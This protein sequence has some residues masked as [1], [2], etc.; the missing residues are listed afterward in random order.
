M[1]QDKIL[2]LREL[3]RSRAYLIDVAADLKRKL[4]A[5]LDR[6]FPEYESLFESLFG[7]S[8]CCG[9]AKVSH[10]PESQ[11]AHLEKLTELFGTAAAAALG[12]GKPDN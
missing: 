9:A 4:I 2:A 5:L 7:E 12:N 11:N 3:C 8:V 10:T 1:P 6:T